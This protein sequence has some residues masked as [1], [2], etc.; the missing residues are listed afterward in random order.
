MLTK[1]VDGA[2]WM[3][4]LGDGTFY[5]MKMM[6]DNH[7]G[8]CG[9][10]TSCDVSLPHA[11]PFHLKLTLRQWVAPEDDIFNKLQESYGFNV[12]TPHSFSHFSQ[13]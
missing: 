1:F 4:P 11:S 7:G 6:R 9:A 12:S 10:L 13:R 3:D 5:C 2:Q 8:G